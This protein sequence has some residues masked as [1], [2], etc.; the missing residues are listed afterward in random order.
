[1]ETGKYI[2][3]EKGKIVETKARQMRIW[4]TT[5]TVLAGILFLVDVVLGFAMISASVDHLKTGSKSISA[6]GDLTVPYSVDDF[7]NDLEVEIPAILVSLAVL[8]AGLVGGWGLRER[9]P[10]VA[11]GL[12]LLVVVSVVVT[13]LLALLLVF[14]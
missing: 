8:A 7:H 13:L 10:R 2:G 12:S 11:I 14:I 1:L 4:L 6:G 5:I 9:K 3:L